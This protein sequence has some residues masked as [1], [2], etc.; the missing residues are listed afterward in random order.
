MAQT[1]DSAQAVA[2]DIVMWMS[3]KILNLISLFCHTTAYIYLLVCCLFFQI[4]HLTV[5]TEIKEVSA[6][7]WNHKVPETSF[8]DCHGTVRMQMCFNLTNWFILL[9]QTQDCSSSDQM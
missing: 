3:P 9:L 1:I 7:C 2:Q 5:L 6:C 8:Q 4:N